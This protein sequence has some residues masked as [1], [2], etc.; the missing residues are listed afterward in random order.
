MSFFE[1]LFSGT[2][3][4]P[5]EPNIRFGRYTDAYKPAEQLAILETAESYFE[6]GQYM[7]CYRTF[8]DYLRDEREDNVRT[9]AVP[10]GLQFE[11]YQGSKK[12]TGL[13]TPQY[14][15]AEAKIIQSTSFNIGILRR[16]LEQNFTLHYSRF[17]LDDE[18]NI[19]ITFNTPTTDGSPYKLY[20]ALR[21]VAT[22]ADKQ[23]DLLVEE[24]RQLQLIEASHLEPLPIIEKRVKYQYIVNAIRK[25]LDL[26]ERPELQQKGHARSLGYLLLELLFRLDYLTKPEGFMME[27][28][29]RLHRKYYQNDGQTTVQKNKMVCNGLRELSE[30]SQDEFFQEM[31]RVRSTFGITPSINHDRVGALIVNELPHMKWYLENSYPHLALA[32]PG[33]IVG[34]CLFDY[35]VPEPDR[36]LFHLYYKIVECDYFKVLGY[37]CRYYDSTTQVFD[38]RGIRRAIQD[39]VERHEDSYPYFKPDLGILQYDSLPIFA[40]SYL[41]MMQGL[42]LTK[43]FGN[44]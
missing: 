41:R 35:A 31:Y 44:K 38:K 34:S 22:K 37:S 24:F 14:V 12:I 17:A 29:E 28:L 11:L 16:L 18:D 1:R 4:E 6:E 43:G 3:D 25:T 42:N 30:R 7:D 2:S 23:D 26:A 9:E 39:I 33:Y 5:K 32:I 20:A 8:F 19:T 36:D 10:G 21:E 13:A 27:T 15:M 40:L